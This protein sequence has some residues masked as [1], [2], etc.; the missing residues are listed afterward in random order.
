MSETHVQKSGLS[1]QYILRASL[2]REPHCAHEENWKDR[3]LSEIENLGWSSDYAERGYT[4][5]VRGVLLA[6]WN[7]FPR[8]IGDTLERA[9]FD[10]QWSDQ[11]TTCGDCGK[12]VRTSGDCYSWQPY[13]VIENE[14]ELVC[15]DCVDWES[16]L[17][18]IEDNADAA[19][20]RACD[21]AKYGYRLVSEPREYQNGMHA[22][23]TDNPTR[24]LETLHTAGHKRIVFRIPET[25]QFYIEFET[26]EKVPDTQPVNVLADPFAC[27]CNGWCE[28]HKTGLPIGETCDCRPI[29][30]DN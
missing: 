26:W 24:I 19:C 27:G 2:C 4:A 29:T 15:L 8:D 22:G 28:C 10:I 5:G 7:Y 17:E 25:S 1:P 12:L 18:S 9:G 21:P 23:M 30:E 16:Y 11:W 13:Y 6:N 20:M 14:C 3:A